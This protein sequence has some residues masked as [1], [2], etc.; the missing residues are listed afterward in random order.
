[1]AQPRGD[2][3][4]DIWSLM[5][6]GRAEPC[7]DSPKSVRMTEKYCSVYIAHGLGLTYNILLYYYSYSNLN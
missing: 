1:M 7:A 6:L 4:V 3:A 5:W 2:G